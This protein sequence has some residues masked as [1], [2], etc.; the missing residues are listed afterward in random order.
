M[1]GDAHNRSR[2]SGTVHCIDTVHLTQGTV[3][4]QEKLKISAQ[5]RFDCFQFILRLEIRN[6][7]TL[8]YIS[9]LCQLKRGER[10]QTRPKSAAPAFV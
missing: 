8:Q 1:F 7:F 10:C 5:D 9:N 3:V 2:L 4:S 6:N